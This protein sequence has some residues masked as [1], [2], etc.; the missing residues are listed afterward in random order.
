MT[1]L[2][3]PNPFPARLDEQERHTFYGVGLVMSRWESLEFEQARIYSFFAGDPD[4][5]SVQLE[6]GKGVTFKERLSILRQKACSFFIRWCHQDIE[7]LFDL[8]TE[9]AEELAQQRNDV[10]HGIVYDVSRMTIFNERYPPT[11]GRKRG[12]ALIPPLYT[13][14]RHQNGLPTYAYA[15]PELKT[16]ASDVSELTNDVREFRESLSGLVAEWLAERP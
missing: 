1:I 4:G 9:R 11:F 5:L 3:N 15:L 12:Y 10:A 8:L 13:L 2:W 14:R 16:L 7:G 6:Y